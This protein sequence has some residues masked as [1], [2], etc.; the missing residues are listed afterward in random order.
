LVEEGSPE[1]SAVE[2][3][4]DD[5]SEDIYSDMF[6]EIKEGIEVRSRLETE[7]LKLIR[8]GFLE[9]AHTGRYSREVGMARDLLKRMLR[10]VK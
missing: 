1:N 10:K 9:M 7:D 4:G 5:G 6:P 3:S 8:Q 2:V